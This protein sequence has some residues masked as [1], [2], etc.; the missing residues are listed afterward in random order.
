MNLE[1]EFLFDEQSNKYERACWTDFERTT[2]LYQDLTM[3]VLEENMFDLK[4]YE[5]QV[6]FAKNQDSL[7]KNNYYQPAILH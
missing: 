2:E 4:L 3:M 7:D 5:T 6:P 1:W